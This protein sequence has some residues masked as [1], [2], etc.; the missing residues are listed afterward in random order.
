VDGGRWAI[1]GFLFQMLGSLG[2]VARV[3]ELESVRQGDDIRTMRITLEPEGGGDAE[4]SSPGKRLVEQYKSRAG[5]RTWSSA[6][7]VDGV[8][9]DLLGAL[10]NGGS[11][12]EARFRFLTNGRVAAE[13][14]RDLMTEISGIGPAPDPF[15]ALDNEKPR[16]RYKGGRITARTFFQQILDTVDK[17]KGD[18][19][20]LWRLLSRMEI[21]DCRSAASFIGQIDMLLIVVVDHREDIPSKRDALI[22]QLFRRAKAGEMVSPAE[23]LRE[24]GI[25]PDRLEK[26]SQ[27]LAR[28]RERT[29]HALSQEGYKRPL[30][31]RS[32]APLDPQGPLTVLTGESGQGK[33]WQLLRLAH[34]YV[35]REIPCVVLYGISNLNELEKALV[36]ILWHESGYDS[37]PPLANILERL[38]DILPRPPAPV[39]TVFIDDVQDRVFADRLL[40]SNFQQMP[41]HFILSAQPRVADALQRSPRGKA[42]IVQVDR[43]SIHE[44]R[45]Y[46]SRRRISWTQLPNDVLGLLRQPIMAK[47]YADTAVEGWSPETEYA[48]LERYWRHVTMERRGQDD[49]PQDVEPVKEL[50]LMLFEGLPYPWSQ[51]AASN[52]RLNDSVQQ[53]LVSVGLLRR[54]GNDIALAHDRLLNWALAESLADRVRDGKLN[55]ESLYELLY[56]ILRVD[57]EWRD[58]RIFLRLRYVPMDLFWLLTNR[59]HPS[60][61]AELI[62]K[63]VQENR[64]CWNSEAI[65]EELL[66][67]LGSRIL[68]A[69]EHLSLYH[70]SDADT[71]PFGRQM[72]NSMLRAG[73]GSEDE[74]RRLASYLISSG[75][76]AVQR[77]GLVVAKAISLPNQLERLWEI[78]RQYAIRKDNID[79]F[80]GVLE[81]YRR[82]ESTAALA[83]AIKGDPGWIKRKLTE[84]HNEDDIV[85]LAY[86]I[87]KLDRPIGQTIW[88]ETKHRFFEQ[89]PSGRRCLAQAIRHFQDRS[90]I[91]WLVKT[92][93]NGAEHLAHVFRFDALIRLEPTKA[94]ELLN[95]IASDRELLLTKNW[96]LRALFQRIGERANAELQRCLVQHDWIG[97]RDLAIIYQTHEDLLDEQTLEV[98]LETFEARLEEHDHLDDW[99]PGPERHFLRLLSTVRSP[100]LLQQLEKK[101]GSRFEELLVRRAIKQGGRKSLSKELDVEEYRL[102]LLKIGGEGI[103]KVLAQDLRSENVWT[104][105][106][107][108]ERAVWHPTED[109][110]QAVREVAQRNQHENVEQ[111]FLMRALASLEEDALFAEMLR[112]G[113]PPYTYA[114]EIRRTKS[115]IPEPVH[116]QACADALSNDETVQLAGIAILSL[117]KGFSKATDRL[118]NILASSAPESGVARGAVWALDDLG[119]ASDEAID[120]VKPML[121]HRDQQM[122]AFNYLLRRGGKAGEAA[123]TEYFA[124][125]DRKEI[126][127][128]EEQAARI[129]VAHEKADGEATKFLWCLIKEKTS[130]FGQNENLLAL[131]QSGDSL[132]QDLLIENSLAEG[133][134]TGS[135]VTA[136][137]GLADRDPDYA[138]EAA[139]RLLAKNPEAGGEDILLKIDPAKAIP[140]LLELL[141]GEVDTLYRW[142]IFRHLR[143]LAPPDQLEAEVTPPAKDGDARK[144]ELA[145]EVIGWL[146]PGSLKSCLH[147]CADDIERDVEMAAL[148]ALASHRKQRDVQ[149]LLSELNRVQDAPAR[150]SR[151]YALLDLFDPRT[152]AHHDDPLCI[153]RT[154]DELPFEFT[155]EAE[156]VL[157][158]RV[159]REKQAAKSVDRNRERN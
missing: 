44:L 150:W 61:L 40:G 35:E 136:I 34:E 13:P 8:L 87:M 56:S 126:T 146:P 120:L 145:C 154:L 134:F 115:R 91:D 147:I 66:P 107:A 113:T 36:S 67:T 140:F 16:F 9:P 53:R 15:G 43:F 24:A 152:L 19:E 64:L 95:R 153:W 51:H 78:H 157:K 17:D 96:W 125:H 58:D 42:A 39:L 122:A 52:A 1:A 92:E 132:A 11:L 10:K 77:V 130:I 12:E 82:D 117:C 65:F 99:Q 100:G 28:F 129:L 55:S 93:I 74:L 5:N 41:V 159:D 155:K 144:R 127:H 26:R 128:I 121:Q 137:R 27:L 133:S 149:E 31:V 57:A 156:R 46:L 123:L 45:D 83:C 81:Y 37:S 6:D 73:K 21:Q 109:V 111:V 62:D 143:W 112:R 2:H 142:R 7:I 114:F 88:D 75:Y 141:A 14:L 98:I 105:A 103:A 116:D 108:L 101:Q 4:V 106:D 69:L 29:L 124:S 85:D 139:S 25:N 30:D 84:V 68:P 32:A 158:R 89:L 90:Y 104:R 79:D 80:D 71:W 118:Q 148:D 70:Q 38:A 97:A 48:L 86:L 22:G 18:A 60:D 151:L 49:H 110:R 23:I 3:A 50:A 94:L 59:M 47:L 76:L 63:L 20:N 102:I 135:P 54:E 138:F 131:T 119:H 72:A 33:T